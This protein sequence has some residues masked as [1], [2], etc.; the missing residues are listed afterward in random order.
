MLTR[1]QIRNFKRIGDA[2]IELGGHV[3]FVG[4]NNS[5]KTSALQAIALWHYGLTQWVAGKSE[6]AASKKRTGVAL[7]RKD[8]I[9]LPVP[10]TNLLWK[11]LHTR[12]GRRNSAGKAI[13]ENVLFEIGCEGIFQDRAWSIT[14][15]FDY[16]N[17][18]L[19]FCRPASSPI[20]QEQISS[21]QRIAAGLQ[22]AL[23]PPM[24][25]LAA[26]EPL[27]PPGR[28]S[29]LVGQGR[30]AEVLRNLCYSVAGSSSEAWDAVSNHLRALFGVNLEAPKFDSA[31]GELTLSYRNRD[32]VLLDI[33]AAGRGLQQTLLLLAYLYAYRGS[34]ILLDEP[35]A[36]LE[37]LRQRQTYDLITSVANSTG[38]QV[39][40]ATHSEEV[41]NRAAGRDTVVA[42]LGAPHRINDKGP[43]LRKSLLSIGYQHYLQAE[44][45]GWV[46][47]LEGSTDAAIL[48]KLALRL[49][50]PA[51]AFLSGA[52]V[53]YLDTNRPPEAQNRFH[54]LREA[55]PTLRGLA[56]FDRLE[57]ALPP[58]P[59]LTM[60]CWQKREIENYVCTPEALLQ[61]ALMDG[62]T[63]RHVDLIEQS[64]APRRREVMQ[65]AISSIEASLSNLGK[66][67]PWG[68]DLKVSEEFLEPLFSLYHKQ[69][70]LPEAAMRKKRFYELAEFIPLTEIDDEVRVVL[71]AIV[72]VATGAL[73]IE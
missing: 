49:R 51:A 53:D 52:Y 18:E 4:T 25:G 71:D 7:N 2:D 59:Q 37:I 34:T 3:V 21:M 62:R 27:L 54:G 33:S 38:S 65:Q 11:D 48:E 8:L 72:S 40:A 44:D 56:V 29:V 36:H 64:E 19:L 6:G 9:A 16:S 35:D 31:R 69:L 47:Y 45:K 22:I 1:L 63:D 24:S 46:L 57:R 32:R 43:Q 58:D 60:L 73:T 70:G 5:G 42:F 13:T 39:I 30:T 14:L 68:G 17:S 50:H 41:L 61:W 55:V 67:S 15:E 26:D 66:P 10:H 28:V 20:T 12:T 23:L